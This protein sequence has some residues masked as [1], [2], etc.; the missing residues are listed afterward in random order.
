MH[1]VTTAETVTLTIEGYGKGFDLA[2]V[3]PADAFGTLGRRERAT[4]L[5]GRC[6]LDS[7]PGE[8]TRV[9]VT[10]PHAPHPA[11]AAT[12]QARQAARVSAG[13][14]ATARGAHSR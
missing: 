9:R 4:L 1:V 13:T 3:G 6:T 5:G 11:P 10:I 14:G 2:R 7:R 8:G 12:V